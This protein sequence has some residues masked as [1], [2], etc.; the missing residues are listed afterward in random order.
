MINEGMVYRQVSLDELEEVARAIVTKLAGTPVWLLYGEMGAGKTTLVKAICDALQVDDVIS[1]P[2]FSI[3][4]EYQTRGGEKLYHFD[5]YRIKNEAEAWDIG[6]DEYFYSGNRCLVEWPE[7]IP[8]LI[9]AEYA[10]L[11][12]TIENS[13]LRTIAISVHDG[14][15]E[16]RI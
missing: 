6:T 16:N 7:K 4:N 14:K 9:P 2:T 8:S 11:V 12:I 1:S 15:E 3:V 10:A 5:F 13:T